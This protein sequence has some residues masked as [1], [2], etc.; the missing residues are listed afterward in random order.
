MQSLTLFRVTGCQSAVT[1]EDRNHFLF[2]YGS[3]SPEA[4]IHRS[5]V[6]KCWG[7][8]GTYPR[9]QRSTKGPC[10]ATYYSWLVP[11]GGCSDRL[12]ATLPE[13]EGPS[14]QTGVW[15]LNLQH[16]PANTGGPRH[17]LSH[18]H[19][20]SRGGDHG[21]DPHWERPWEQSE[22]AGAWEASLVVRSW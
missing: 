4:R 21:T 16:P 12:P 8:A 1:S 14:R 9:K 3:H 18:I 11:M 13:K 22:P 5:R 19:S 17:F 20:R 10:D 15:W 2:G 7:K 6:Q